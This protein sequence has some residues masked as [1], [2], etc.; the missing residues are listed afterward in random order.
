M[1]SQTFTYRGRWEWQCAKG[2]CSIYACLSI[3][4]C[5]SND[6]GDFVSGIFRP[7]PSAHLPACVLQYCVPAFSFFYYNLNASSELPLL[8]VLHHSQP[9]VYYCL[10]AICLEAWWFRLVTKLSNYHVF[11]QS[12]VLTKQFRCCSNTSFDSAFFVTKDF[13]PEDA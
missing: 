2:S 1:H 8:P 12:V 3:C 10:S 9:A 7:S 4:Q 6:I 11:T 13:N 5:S